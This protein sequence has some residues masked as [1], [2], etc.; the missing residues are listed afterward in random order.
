MGY[1]NTKKSACQSLNSCYIW[2][3]EYSCYIRADS[4]ELVN[5]V[6]NPDIYV[7]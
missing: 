3:K 4:N 2:G 7:A 1:S 6:I 5:Y